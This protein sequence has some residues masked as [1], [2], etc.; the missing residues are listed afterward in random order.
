MGQIIVYEPGGARVAGAHVEVKIPA[1]FIFYYKRTVTTD[2]EGVATFADPG[3]AYSN[4]IAKVSITANI[5]GNEYEYRGEW[6]VNLWGV[7]TPDVKEVS[8]SEQEIPEPGP[9]L[10][11][12]LTE[13]A[14]WIVLG[15]AA[16]VVLGPVSKAITAPKRG[17]Y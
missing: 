6:N 15:V 1:G 2:L 11:A 10:A 8:L 9:N 13:N 7:W 5:D 4:N 17:F 16:I 14:K 12:V 3:L